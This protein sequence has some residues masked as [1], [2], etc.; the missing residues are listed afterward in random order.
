MVAVRDASCREEQCVRRD[1]AGAR[2]PCIGE[3]II[4]L[5]KSSALHLSSWPARVNV[6]CALPCCGWFVRARA[7]GCLHRTHSD[8][9][10]TQDATFPRERRGGVQVEA[11]LSIGHDAAGTHARPCVCT[12]PADAPRLW[13]RGRYVQA[14]TCERRLLP[15]RAQ[16]VPAHRADVARHRHDRP[17]LHHHGEAAALA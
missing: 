4:S 8:G 7:R 10:N 9:M 6:H 15:R 14:G 12:L 5:R 17:H 11:D 16:M 2:G 3:G 13:P 1:G